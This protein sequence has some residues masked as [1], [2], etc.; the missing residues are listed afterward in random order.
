MTTLP[1]TPNTPT[2][3]TTRHRVS[4][5]LLDAR[6]AA[7]L[8]QEELASSLGVTRQ[9]FAGWEAADGGV[10][11]ATLD[12]WANALDLEI[13]L[14]PTQGIPT[15]TDSSGM[16]V[17][18]K[19][20]SAHVIV[21]GPNRAHA[22][23]ALSADCGGVPV[24]S[25]GGLTGKPY[26]DRELATFMSDLKE[27]KAGAAVVMVEIIDGQ[28]DAVLLGLLRY[29]RSN[30]VRV[31]IGAERFE[32]IPAAVAQNTALTLYCDGSET[33]SDKD[34]NKWYLLDR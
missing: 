7:G 23:A 14:I 22:L 25:I 4:R 21:V 11:L 3:Y 2:T 33:L 9:A 34:G 26:D 15:L 31:L 30:G 10:T 27:F 18:A 17:P 8:S 5:R 20:L 13:A 1:T 28:A 24:R 19:T 6:G 16:S 12:K 29:A 32:D